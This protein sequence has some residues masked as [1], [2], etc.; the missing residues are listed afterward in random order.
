MYVVDFHSFG[1]RLKCSGKALFLSALVVTGLYPLMALSEP[2][3]VRMITYHTHPPFI[4]NPGA[5]FTYDLAAFLTEESNGRFAFAVSPMS[6]P[7]VDKLISKAETY[8]VPWVNPI[9]FKD[10][11]EARYLWTRYMLMKDSNAVVSSKAEP[12]DYRGPDSLVGLTLGGIRGHRYAGVDDFI[13][14]GASIKRINSDRHQSNI[15]KLIKGRINVTIMPEAAAR[16]LIATEQRGD[17]LYLS[18][19][20][21]SSYARRAFVT[22]QRGDIRDFL[23]EIFGNLPVEPEWKSMLRRYGWDD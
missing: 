7:R 11:N 15:R 6:R 8:V 20:P 16:Y 9:W 14:S 22:N 17:T 10:K 3:T 13:A 1:S 18:P 5:G 2:E 12:V 21:H 23:D 4:N 19:T